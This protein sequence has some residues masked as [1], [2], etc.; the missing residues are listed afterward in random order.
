VKLIIG[1]GGKKQ[2]GWV[3]T[4]QYQIDIVNGFEYFLGDTKVDAMLIE[5]ILEHIPKD[6]ILPALRNCYKYL[7]PDG[8]LRISTPD[9]YHPSPEYIKY[10]SP[11]NMGHQVLYNYHVLSDLLA[12]AGFTVEL[13]EWFDE[14]GKFNFKPWNEIDGNIERC[15]ASDPRNQDGKP[16]YTSLIVDAKK[17]IEPRSGLE[18][19]FEFIHLND[20]RGLSIYN[21][22]KATTF[23]ELALMSPV[24][25]IIELGSY[26]GFGTVPL[27][28]GSQ[29]GKNNKVIA[30]DSYTTC[31]GWIG[32]PYVPEDEFIWRENMI[33]ANVSPILYKGECRELA[34]VWAEP[35]ALLIH[36]LGSRDRMVED[37]MAW[38]KHFVLGGILA[39][40]DLD[41]FSMGTEEAIIKLISTGRWGKRKDWPAFITSVE[42]IK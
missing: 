7:N 22:R 13:L 42:R 3:S 15:L 17:I 41:D 34:S 38:E 40:R 9:G 5:D 11:P 6:K 36:D 23:Y 2:E 30:I 21:R 1:A 27:W 24:G 25:V 19:A 18:K 8:Y 4:E 32:E 16:H 20:Q 33:K 26:H 10:V 35:I 29:D 28:Y 14:N 37:V 39:M 12:Q 31:Y